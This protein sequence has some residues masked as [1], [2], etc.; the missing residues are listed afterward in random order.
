M[1]MESERLFRPV[2]RRVLLGTRCRL[3]RTPHAHR[4]HALG[5]FEETFN[6]LTWH[7]I[8]TSGRSWVALGIPSISKAQADEFYATFYAPANITLVLVGDF[9][10]T[11]AGLWPNATSAASQTG[12]GLPPDVVTLE[13]PPVAE[14]AHERRG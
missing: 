3:R 11:K 1:W 14:K 12:R 2:F 10:A 8:P 7:H 9:E 5:K 4:I 13:V 6:G